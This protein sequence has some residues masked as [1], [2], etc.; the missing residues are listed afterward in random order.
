MNKIIPQ[1]SN[2]DLFAKWVYLNQNI[3]RTEK[4]GAVY[5]AM[6]DLMS[7]IGNALHKTDL[8]MRWANFKRSK[9]MRNMLL[10]LQH[11]HFEGRGRP[12]ECGDYAAIIFVSTSISPE[13]RMWLAK[14]YANMSEEEQRY[15]FRLQSEG[16]ALHA[17][18]IRHLH[19]IGYLPT[20]DD[21]DP[22]SDLGYN[23]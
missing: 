18:E 17:E 10:N 19:M 16:K 12:V 15:L 20:P 11:I 3:R 21:D 5:F 2:F 9:D 8:R 1:N 6:I 7:E 14:Q 22:F 4:D 23:R 13:F